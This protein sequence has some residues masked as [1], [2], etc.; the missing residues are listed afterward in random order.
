MPCKLSFRYH[1][2]GGYAAAILLFDW[3]GWN[4]K[5]PE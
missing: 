2:L 4:I 5:Y 3:L 1:G